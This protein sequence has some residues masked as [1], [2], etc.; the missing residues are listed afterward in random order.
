V[1]Y[2]IYME[3]RAEKA[4]ANLPQ[5]DQL[6]V[7]VVIDALSENPRPQGCVPVKAAPKGTYRVRVGD[8]RVVYLVL[9]GER[10]VIVAK[11][12]R[13]DERTYRDISD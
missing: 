13:R 2:Q 5:K 1:H 6:R 11:V 12:A 3:R 4:L 9:D 10:Q 8:Y 7:L